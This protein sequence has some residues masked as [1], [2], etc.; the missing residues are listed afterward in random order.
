MTSK[1]GSPLWRYVLTGVAVLIFACLLAFG[2]YIQATNRRIPNGFGPE[3][4]CLD[5]SIKYPVCFRNGSSKPI[6]KA[7]PKR[8]PLI[9]N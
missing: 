1:G 9:S 8:A 2:V 5:Q 3:W 7:Q 4:A 6:P